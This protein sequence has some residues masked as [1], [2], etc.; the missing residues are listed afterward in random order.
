MRRFKITLALVFMVAALSV[1]YAY[2]YTLNSELSTVSFA[3]IKMSYVVEPAYF[4]DLKGNI[5]EEGKLQI[6]VPISSIETG[7]SSETNDSMT[8][9]LFLSCFQTQLSKR[10]FQIT[11]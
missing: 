10:L 3:T 7:I 4:K 8:C 9:F 5:S 2:G 6:S 11:C 1:R